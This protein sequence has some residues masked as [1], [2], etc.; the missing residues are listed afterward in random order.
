MICVSQAEK[1][2]GFFERIIL[3]SFQCFD[4]QNLEVVETYFLTFLLLNLGISV[5]DELFK[6]SHE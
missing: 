6:I 3:T 2:R 5:E 1:S 4:S